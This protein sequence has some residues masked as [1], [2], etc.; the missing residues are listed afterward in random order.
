MFLRRSFVFKAW[1]QH[2]PKRN[3]CR[4]HWP[5][6]DVFRI[7]RLLLT[8]CVIWVFAEFI[9]C[10]NSQHR[11]YIN[12]Q[13]RIQ[14]HAFLG[15]WVFLPGIPAS[16]AFQPFQSKYLNSSGPASNWAKPSS[17]YPVFY[18]NHSRHIFK[19]RNVVLLL[20]FALCHILSATDFMLLSR[21]D[22]LT[23]DTKSSK[24]WEVAN[25]S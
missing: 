16:Q 1:Y 6:F 14:A 15:P 21:S 13:Q 10:Q 9:I 7:W 20:R 17:F 18:A 3:I 23:T 11:S 12:S 4:N 8:V 25:A 24:S 19:F 22:T 2:Y 5:S